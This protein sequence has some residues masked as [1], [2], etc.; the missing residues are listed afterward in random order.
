MTLSQNVKAQNLILS[1]FFP[2]IPYSETNPGKSWIHS[3]TPFLQCLRFLSAWTLLFRGL[4]ACL[5]WPNK[6]WTFSKKSGFNSK[7]CKPLLGNTTSVIQ[8]KI[9]SWF[10]PI[11]GIHRAGMPTCQNNHPMM[12]GIYRDLP[13]TAWGWWHLFCSTLAFCEENHKPQAT[14]M[15]KTALHSQHPCGI[16]CCHFFSIRFTSQKDQSATII[17]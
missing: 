1:P 17:Y 6:K 11:H 15:K 3:N 5:S 12:K 13:W 7:V 16:W 9:G 4:S 10:I 8:K 2:R 14:W